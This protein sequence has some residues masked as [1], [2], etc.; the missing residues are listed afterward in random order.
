MCFW[1]YWS[2]A[3]FNTILAMLKD[4]PEDKYLSN[5]DDLESGT[6]I[7]KDRVLPFFFLM[8]NSYECYT[9]DR[10]R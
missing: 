10:E 7:F 4:H 2:Q 3:I 1:A 6:I 9:L 8:L 5:E